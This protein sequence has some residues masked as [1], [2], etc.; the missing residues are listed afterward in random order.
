MLCVR[1]DGREVDVTPASLARLVFAGKVDRSSPSRIPGGTAERPLE[2]SVGSPHGEALTVELLSCLRRMYSPDASVID[3]QE[4]RVHVEDLCQWHWASPHIAARFFWT[5]AWLNELTDHFENAIGYYDAFL[6][7]ACGENQLRVL[8]CNNRGGLR[9]R[10]GRLEGVQDL[11]RSAILC[12]DRATDSV[13]VAGLPAACFNLLNLINA[14]LGVEPLARVVDRELVDFFSPVSTGVR[15][16]WLGQEPNGADRDSGEDAN[17]WILCDPTYRRLNFLTT[18]LAFQAG[19]LVGSDRASGVGRSLPAASQLSLWDSCA[20]RPGPDAEISHRDA[21]YVNNGNYER[22]AEAA[23]LLLREDI[24]STLVKLESPLSRAERFAEEELADIE[25]H[26]ARD[27]WE[28]LRPRLQVQRGI[29]SSLNRQ[30]RA[31]SL[32]ARV[33]AQLERV[34]QLERQKK[35]S[36]LQ[37]ACGRLISEVERFCTITDL[38]EADAEFDDLESRLQQLRTQPVT[39]AG[40]EVTVLLDE[41]AGRFHRHMRRLRRLEIRRTIRG[42]YRHVRR[43]RPADRRTPVPE[44]VY[45]AVAQCHVSDP[46]GLVR[47]W[48]AM[49]ERLD[50]HQGQY[51]IH[52]ALSAMQSDEVSWDAA[53]DD[54]AEALRLDPDLWPTVAPLFGL[55]PA[56]MPGSPSEMTTGAQ[57]SSGTVANRL[58]R[59]ASQEAVACREPTRSATE[60]LEQAF[61]RID[62]KR[63]LRLWKHVETTLSAI[64]VVGDIETISQ[65]GALAE[66]CLDCW[67]AGRPELPG[68]ADPRNPVNLFL[69]SCEKARRLVEAEQPLNARPPR[70][71]EAESLFAEVIESGLDTRDQLRR[72]VTG[73]YLAG[74]HEKDKTQIQRQVLTELEAWVRNVPEEARQRLSPQDISGAIEAVREAVSAQRPSSDVDHLSSDRR[75]S[76][77]I[78]R[79]VVRRGSGAGGPEAGQ[80]DAGKEGVQPEI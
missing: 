45:R 20:D 78:E 57:A 75:V 23:S 11:M 41:L 52:R 7:T 8:A 36:E 21:P 3:I 71:V 61:R 59:A 79:T 48:T 9:I 68:P 15:A 70:F 54:L 35:Q 56:P 28:S 31:T 50:A 67:P 4:L 44:S 32:I 46:G 43:S 49:E 22:Y 62:G 24:P 47:D 76:P 60:V 77:P 53:R 38:C 14:C 16:F 25:S 63:W 6:Q 37:K 5:A 29:L 72:A 17:Q 1:I 64:L 33:D 39:V 51:H 13:P 66:G 55:S 73:L 18:R 12:E 69:E 27:H 74:F 26:L 34:A 2:Q 19:R 40:D 10:L 80:S 30:G 65:V 58:F 42:P